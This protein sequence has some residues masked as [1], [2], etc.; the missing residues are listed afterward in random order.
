MLNNTLDLQVK[1]YLY[2]TV[3]LPLKRLNVEITPVQT[4]FVNK[5][6]GE[7]WYVELSR[8]PVA[9]RIRHNYQ[10]ERLD[11]KPSYIVSIQRSGSYSK[12]PLCRY[13]GKEHSIV[14]FERGF[15]TI[16][17]PNLL[18]QFKRVFEGYTPFT[19]V[20]VNNSKSY[21]VQLMRRMGISDNDS[22]Y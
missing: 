9:E 5:A 4:P 13:D 22:T 11:Y 14:L 8:T 21:Y 17:A 19:N 2:S 7:M 12:V 3:V 6:S 10:R 1:H 16:K 18:Q 15:K 20:E